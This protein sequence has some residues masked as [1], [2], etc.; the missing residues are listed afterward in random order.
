MRPTWAWRE[1]DLWD[2][3][4]GGGPGE[5]PSGSNLPG[6]RAILWKRI[7]GTDP[8]DERLPMIFPCVNLAF[9]RTA[10]SAEALCT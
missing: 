6:L 4:Y 1:L 3:R 9:Q 10:G 5:S 8:E 2:A 7:L